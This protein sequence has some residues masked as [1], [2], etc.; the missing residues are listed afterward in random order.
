MTKKILAG[1]ALFLLLC[2]AGVL[3]VNAFI[4][5]S[6]IKTI[7]TDKI[8]EMTGR[9]AVIEEVHFS[10]V[11]GFEL[12][13]LTVFEKDLS[14]PPFIHIDRLQFNVLY[15]AIL[16]ER[17][18]IIPTL[19]I[20]NPRV[21]LIRR[22]DN[23][24]NF[25]NIAGQQFAPSASPSAST[26][27]IG[28]I[29]LSNATVSF[30]DETLTPSFSES[31][32]NLNLSAR[33]SL[34]INIKFQL[35][36]A[37]AS[38]P[39]SYVSAQGAYSLINKKLSSQ[40]HL[41]DIEITR[42]LN[43]YSLFK[44]ISVSAGKISS[45]DIALNTQDQK[46]NLKG[47]VSIQGL[48]VALAADKSFS[49]NPSLEISLAYVPGREQPLDY[50]G[51]ISPNQGTLTGLPYVKTAEKIDGKIFFDAKG[52]KT[53][54][55]SFFVSGQKIS[56]S[57]TLQDFQNP[58]LDAA[59]SSLNISMDTLKSI[60][61]D[62]WAKNHI[63]AGG[64]CD[65]SLAVKGP[66]ASL[67]DLDIQGTATLM[68]ADLKAKGLPQ[69]LSH[70]NG[71]I[72]YRKTKI[73]F[74]D[75]HAAFCDTPFV[76]SGF[77]NN[78]EDPY[79]EI[80]IKSQPFDLAKLAEV[81]PRYLRKGNIEDIAGQA[82]L[83]AKYKGNVHNVAEGDLKAAIVLNNTDISFANMPDKIKS[84][85]GKIS[86]SLNA[87]SWQDLKGTFKNI[88]YTLNGKIDDLK[89]PL[90]Q[91]SLASEKLSLDTRIRWKNDIL[92]IDSC[93][94]KYLNSAFRLQGSADV[95]DTDEPK[96]DI[97]GAADLD[98]KD[99]AV[100]M[101]PLSEK[102]KAIRP[103]GICTL[104]G[105]AHGPVKDWS[106]LAISL[107]V[108]GPQISLY[109]YRLANAQLRFDQ[110][111]REIT[112]CDLTADAYDGKLTFHSTA[113]LSQEG[114]PYLFNSTLEKVNLAKF[115]EDSIWKSQNI[116]GLLSIVMNAKGTL[117]NLKDI[118][119]RGALLLNNGR[120]WQMNLL[121]GL[122]QFLFIPEFENIVFTEATG[123]LFVKNQKLSTTDFQL[124]S[125]PVTLDCSG[126][127]DF[128]GNID[129]DVISEFSEEAIAESGSLKKALTAILT[130]G[131]AYLTIKVNGSLKEPKYKLS[132]T[133][134]L[135]KTT[136]LLFDSIKGMF[137]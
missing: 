70:I 67:P 45:A 130:Q 124:I 33:F 47:S 62:L 66:L 21:S 99:L 79:A 88:A 107:N 36:G 43:P 95:S 64:A 81:F 135:K 98:L 38:S 39:A 59:L 122:G 1:M 17:K 113:D 134:V 46:L 28:N 89:N 11:K 18:I 30:L 10:V 109:G 51:V 24:W 13:G 15:L 82:S 78:F 41:Q 53:D 6:K 118:D 8:T 14:Q 129:F 100:L 75:I 87:V 57:G 132:S 85:S 106:S 9:Q 50:E 35:R 131:E 40:I 114:M 27:L 127:M 117:K 120:I 37:L 126:W 133:G 65:I 76:V 121:K 3:Y 5:P 48:S 125:Q 72:N 92:Q 22:P 136:N 71:K 61:P 111:N 26:F 77:M 103:D 123:E 104:Q 2:M 12:T 102:I 93:K 84:L 128:N 108:S 16:K 55:L 49:G 86:A 101:P 4:L 115:R 29:S 7:I 119:G 68:N 52:L 105:S 54:D 83:T 94:G 112:Q 58:S 34:P 42:Y 80:N 97:T 23:N 74:E 137:E 32:Q 90:I 63:E 19:K 69:P 91:T 96:I 25:S 110:E 73:I 31:L 60:F 44:D 116:D 56:A 20:L